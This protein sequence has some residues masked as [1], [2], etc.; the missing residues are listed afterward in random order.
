MP[1]QKMQKQRVSHSTEKRKNSIEKKGPGHRTG[2]ANLAGRKRSQKDREIKKKTP[3]SVLPLGE[4]IAVAAAEEE[5]LAHT[6]ADIDT[7]VAV[8]VV[9]IVVAP[10]LA[11]AEPRNCIAVVDAVADTDDVADVAVVDDGENTG[12]VEEEDEDDVIGAFVA[13]GDHEELRRHCLSCVAW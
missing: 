1:L 4:L 5:A 12:R 13:L 9:P 7:A 2:Q 8:A 3:H 11:V 10:I 6:V